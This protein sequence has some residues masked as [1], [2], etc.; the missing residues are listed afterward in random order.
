MKKVIFLFSLFILLS[1]KSNL[2]NVIKEGS[3]DSCPNQSVET[4][5]NSFFK[6]PKWESF[7][8]PEDDKFHLNASGQILY[9]NKKVN[10]LIQ[11]EIINEDRWQINAFEINGEPQDDYMIEELIAEM[12]EESSK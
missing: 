8:S 6:N 9:G 2:E 3:F 5:V 4:L 11:F 7:V 1:C 10:A 12:C